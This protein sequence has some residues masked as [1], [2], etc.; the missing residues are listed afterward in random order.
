L[1][2]LNFF[3][4]ASKPVKKTTTLTM[5]VSWGKLKSSPGLS[6]K[7]TPDPVE[8]GTVPGE[9]TRAAC[10]REG[11]VSAKASAVSKTKRPLVMMGVLNNLKEASR[12]SKPK[13]LSKNLLNSL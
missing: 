2:A 9:I 13:T 5:R 4:K 7:E 3:R 6:S 10:S 8:T 11:L 12:N 1:N